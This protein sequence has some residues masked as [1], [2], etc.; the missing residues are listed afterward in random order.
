MT[1][2][3]R[4]KPNKPSDELKVTPSK[5]RR[6]LIIIL[7]LNISQLF[8]SKDQISFRYD[9][10]SKNGFRLVDILREPKKQAKYWQKS[11]D[12]R[13]MQQLSEVFV[14]FKTY[15]CQS[16]IEFRH[17][18]KPRNGSLNFKTY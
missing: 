1:K 3:R 16:Q 6:D 15:Y 13:L 8:C 5:G 14:T 9:E 12:K 18:A 11:K 7:T 4:Y 10:K 2:V 17:I